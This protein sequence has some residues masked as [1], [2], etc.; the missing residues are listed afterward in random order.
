MITTL[1]LQWGYVAL[2]SYRSPEVT[3]FRS[4]GQAW[5]HT[6][7]IYSGAH[8]LPCPALSSTITHACQPN[9]KAPPTNT[10]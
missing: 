5:I 10:S 4:E 8:P 7:L 9:T 6:Q 2:R 1:L 3:E